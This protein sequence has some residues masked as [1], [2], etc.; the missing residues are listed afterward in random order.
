MRCPD[1]KFCYCLSPSWKTWW[2][3]AITITT[4]IERQRV[5]LQVLKLE[6]HVLTELTRRSSRHFCKIEDK[7]RYGGFNYVVMT[8]VGKSLEVCN[9]M[10]ADYGLRGARLEWGWWQLQS[11]E[12]IVSFRG[13]EFPKKDPISRFCIGLTIVFHVSHHENFELAKAL[14]FCVWEALLVR[15]KADLPFIKWWKMRNERKNR[16]YFRK[17]RML[18]AESSEKWTRR[19]Y[20]AGLLARSWHSGTWGSRGSPSNWLPAS[21]RQGSWRYREN[22]E[23]CIPMIWEYTCTRCKIEQWTCSRHYKSRMET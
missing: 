19:P 17:W 9:L 8:L 21:R 16:L 23:F 15:N 11:L 2:I 5:M 6:V 12:V 1:S 4:L 7:G 14:K 10:I 13:E 3:E 18:I 20:D 22:A